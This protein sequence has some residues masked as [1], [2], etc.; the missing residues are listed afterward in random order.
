MQIMDLRLDISQVWI[1]NKTK[2]EHGVEFRLKGTR[3]HF[4]QLMPIAVRAVKEVLASHPE[5]D[6]P[7]AFLFRTSH[8]NQL[9]YYDLSRRLK[10]YAA[11]G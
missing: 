7:R 11:R 2:E 5:R 8:E 10:T 9:P 3:E 6:N 4:A 1:G